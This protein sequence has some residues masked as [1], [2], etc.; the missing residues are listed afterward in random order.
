MYVIRAEKSANHD[1]VEGG[2]G[3]LESRIR[4]IDGVQNLGFNVDCLYSV[5]IYVPTVPTSTDK[6]AIRGR[7]LLV[8]RRVSPANF[9]EVGVQTI[10]VN[11]QMH[12]IMA[13]EQIRPTTW[14]QMKLWV[15]WLRLYMLYET[16]RR[17]TPRGIIEGGD[18]SSNSNGTDGSIN[19]Y[20]INAK[21]AGTEGNAGKVVSNAEGKVQM[22]LVEL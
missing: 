18:L 15:F 17:R 14:R 4:L 19:A 22:P 20:V 12:S 2:R 8:K 13:R 9:A 11:S 7:A 3:Q 16:R 1:S 10:I 21:E 6:Q 5:Q